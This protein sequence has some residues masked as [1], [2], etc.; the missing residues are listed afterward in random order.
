[1]KRTDN[2]L[3]WGNTDTGMDRSHNSCSASSYEYELSE[4]GFIVGSGEICPH[5]GEECED[6][7]SLEF[8][9]CL[10]EK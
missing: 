8:C 2:I 6:E 1:M 10:E 5:C 9:S 4:D 3:D 7:A